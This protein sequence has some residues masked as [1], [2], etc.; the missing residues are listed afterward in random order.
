MMKTV[1]NVTHNLI[2]TLSNKY[3]CKLILIVLAITLFTVVSFIE[4]SGYALADTFC[5]YEKC[6]N[7]KAT[8]QEKLNGSEKCKEGKQNDYEILSKPKRS[9]ITVLSIHGGRIEEYTS[10]ISYDLSQRYGWNRYDF[11]GHIETPKCLNLAPSDSRIK[12]FDVLHITAK[13]FDEEKAVDLVSSHEKAIAIHGHG[14]NKNEDNPQT[15]CVGGRN[16]TQIKDFIENVKKESDKL[17]SLL[18]YSL[19]LVDVPQ[20]N[21]SICI[22]RPRLNGTEADNIVNKNKGDSGG[23]QLELSKRIREDLTK[24]SDNRADISPDNY[25]LFRNVMYNAINCAMVGR[26]VCPSVLPR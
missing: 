18:N 6:S 15:I 11:N 7:P 1:R 10:E 24:G 19:N 21:D 9:S 23:L 22:K 26:R 20:A 2:K 8:L 5:G 4:S 13:Y 12:N 16:K 17:E 14:R 25:Q 3:I